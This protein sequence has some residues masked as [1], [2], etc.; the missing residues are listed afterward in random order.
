[1][2]ST[3]DQPEQVLPFAFKLIMHG[4]ERFISLPKGFMNDCNLN[5]FSVLTPMPPGDGVEN[6]LLFTYLYLYTFYSYYL[7]V[8][9]FDLAPV[10]FLP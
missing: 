10:L 5:A 9:G 8:P 2:P 7:L 1:M 3:F 6:S 4:N